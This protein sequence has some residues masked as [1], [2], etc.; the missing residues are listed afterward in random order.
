MD[1]LFQKAHKYYD[2]KLLK[3]VRRMGWLTKPQNFDWDFL[4]HCDE[5][6]SLGIQLTKGQ[7]AVL[8]KMVDECGIALDEKRHMVECNQRD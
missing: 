2:R 1:F 6:A 7:L 5:K 4:A 3:L 8:D